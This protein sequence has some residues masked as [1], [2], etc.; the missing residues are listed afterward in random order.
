MEGAR[1]DTLGLQLVRNRF[2]ES[3]EDAV[4]ADLLHCFDYGCRLARPCNRF[5]NGVACARFNEGD[6]PMIRAAIFLAAAAGIAG[7]AQ[8]AQP[9]ELQPGAAQ[10]R[11]S[12]RLNSSH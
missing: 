8:A 3:K 12:T 11:K 9:V 1:I 7:S 5:N 10:D 2:V 6:D 4:A